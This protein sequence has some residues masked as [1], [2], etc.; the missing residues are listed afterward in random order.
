VNNE[1]IIAKIIE[2]FNLIETVYAV[3]LFGSRVKGKNREDSDVDIAVLFDECNLKLVR[4]G[5]TL[6]WN[7]I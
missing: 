5:N 1:Y 7:L 6:I 4:E 2:Y 3:Y